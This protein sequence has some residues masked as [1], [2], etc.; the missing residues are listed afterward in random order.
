MV[1]PKTRAV[2]WARSAGRCHYCNSS[3][4]GDYISGN[5]DANFG[6]V[7]HIV[8]D[9]PTGP[10]GDPI[11]SPQLEDNVSNLMLMCYPHHKLIDRDEL[12]QYPEQ[13][14]LDMKAVHEERIRILTDVTQDR[15]SHVL[16]YGAKIGEHDS[17]VSFRRVR[18][19]MLPQRYPYEG[20]SIGIGIAGNIA[21]DDED[22]FWSIEPDNLKQQFQ[23]TISE[24]ISAREIEHLSVFGLGPIPLLVE[25]GS[26][27]GDITPADIYQLH[28]E[29]AGWRWAED[30]PRI[31]FVRSRPAEI[32]P[33]IA[34]KLG[35]SATVTDDRIASVLGDDV[36]IWSLTA[37]NPN[38]DIMRH[39]ADL[40][41]YRRQIRS[42]FDEIKAAHGQS[43]IINVF[44]AIPVSCAV[45]TGRVRM[46]K[47]DLPLLIYD[48]IANKGFISRLT[49]GS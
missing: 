17:P 22:K 6:F 44:P 10:R 16:R 7:A 3:L 42:L 5:E 49:I 15:S 29:P 40:A 2:L 39:A 8:A 20:R 47:A 41:E 28:R 46:P 4:I 11:R 13:R 32:K 12:D 14:L 34:L 35:I 48:Q 31:T 23:R 18:M 9:K 43:G 45:E 1:S 25:L 33:K 36:A 38:N 19:A 24:R 30:G 37:E 27:L 26:L 21:T